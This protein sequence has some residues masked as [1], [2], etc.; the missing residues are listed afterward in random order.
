M[1]LHSATEDKDVANGDAKLTGL[2]VEVTDE[3]AIA[4]ARKDF[5]AHTGYPPPAGPMHLFRID[6]KELSFLRPNGDHL[7]DRDVARRRRA[8]H[9]QALLTRRAT[10]SRA[11]SGTGRRRP[12]RWRRTPCPARRSSS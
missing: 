5:A 7:A 10:R 9:D 1:A 6:V 3:A 11:R 8:A 12:W 2:A 4:Q